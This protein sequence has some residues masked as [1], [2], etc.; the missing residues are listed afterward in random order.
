M[1]AALVK[2]A[3]G[4]NHEAMEHAA[5]LSKGRMTESPSTECHRILADIS[6]YLDGELD[7]TACD[8]IERHCQACQ[9]CAALVKGLRE[10]VGLCRQAASVPLP[11]SVQERARAS[12]RQLLEEDKSVSEN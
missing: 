5:T 1:Y 8:A 2:D 6:A 4:G 7:T 3:A 9:R 12:V 11:E 10:T